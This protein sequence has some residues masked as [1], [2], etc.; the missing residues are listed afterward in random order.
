MLRFLK[1]MPKPAYEVAIQ[2][3]DE[4]LYFDI[5][6]RKFFYKKIFW[7]LFAIFATLLL[8]AAWSLAS[9]S[10]TSYT[11]SAGL[12]PMQSLGLSP[13]FGFVL[14]LG[15]LFVGAYFV[16]R[17]Y[18]QWT[19]TFLMLTFKKVS[20]FE[21]VNLWLLLDGKKEQ[22]EYCSRISG[23][24]LHDPTLMEL[25]WFKD[26]LS[27]TIKTADSEGDLHSPFNGMKDIRDFDNLNQQIDRV[28]AYY[29]HRILE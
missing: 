26:C 8:I 19:H 23:A 22:K 16:F 5:H 11:N 10:M 17:A 9:P 25:I 1:D 6:H 27:F 21:P 28:K 13:L 18:Y 14:V 29:D 15:T 12:Q 24:I 7:T 2:A 20:I 3:D 4:V